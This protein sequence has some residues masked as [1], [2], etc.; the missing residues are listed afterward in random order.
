MIVSVLDEVLGLE[1]AEA[2]RRSDAASLI[3]VKFCHG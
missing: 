3:V 2:K 1:G